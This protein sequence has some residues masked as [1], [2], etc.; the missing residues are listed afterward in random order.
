MVN[1]RFGSA[2]SALAT[3]RRSAACAS[4]G[5]GARSASIFGGKVDTS[6]IGLATR[7]LAALEAK[8]IRPPRSSSP[9]ARSPSSPNDAGF[10][11]CSATPISPPGRFASAEA[12]YRGFAVS[13]MPNQPQVVLKLALVADRPGQERRSAGASSTRPA[14][15]STRPTTAL[16]WRLPASRTRRSRCSSRRPA[17][18]APTPGSAR[19]SRS[20]MPL[21]GDWTAARTVAAQDVP[22]DQ[23]DARI[24]QWMTLRQAG[25]RFGPGRGADRRHPGRRRSG[26]AGPPRAAPPQTS[27]AGRRRAGRRCTPVAEAGPGRW[28][29]KLPAPAA[30]VEYAGRSGSRSRSMVA[31]AAPV[32]V[33]EARQ[34]QPKRAAAKAPVAKP[35]AQPVVPP[36]SADSRPGCPQ[37]RA[38]RRPPAAISKAVVQLG[39]Y[40]R[41]RRRRRAWNNVAKK[42]PALRGYAPMSARFDSPKGTVYRL[43]VKGFA[44]DAE[45]QRL[46][47][48]ALKRAGGSC[49]VRSR[50]RRAG[51]ARL[52]LSR[53]AASRSRQAI[54]TATPIST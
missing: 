19:I 50:R 41:P 3:D 17:R 40:A 43:S 30:P 53:S 36:A 23:L 8:A 28:S 24:Q 11:A 45:A 6:K 10:R 46:C 54:R 15:C 27:R 13:L 42:Y 31:A 39:A 47:C 29:P 44:S 9:S 18:P 16:R 51:P 35:A 22:A 48:G 7:A 12:A 20:L 34:P 38:S 37:G 2:L 21:P 25:P 52:A 14:T 33:V 4:P 32:P 1:A 49:F 5:N 26:P